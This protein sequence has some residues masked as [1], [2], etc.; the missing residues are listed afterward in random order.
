MPR[1]MPRRA[2]R[3][4]GHLYRRGKVWWFKWFD[5]QGQ[6]HW[7]S[8]G[9]R[10]RA[11]AET[12]LRDQLGQRD[13]GAPVLPDPRR[14]SVDSLLEILKTEYRLNRRRSLDRADLSCRHLLR[15]FA[16][17]AAA[18]VT[19]VDV[20]KYCDLRLGEGVAPATVNRELAALRRAYRLAR[21][22]GVIATMPAITALQE[23]NVRTGFLE[24]DQFTTVCRYLQPTEADCARFMYI[25]GWR[26]RSEVFPLSWP[27]VDWAG[28]LVR[29]EP[30]TT[31]NRKGR[32]FPL[33]PQLRVLLERRLEHTRRCER[34]QGRI[35]PYVFHRSGRPIKSMSKAWRAGCRKAGAPGR[36]LHDLR[37][38]AVRNLERAGVS[39]SVA[40]EMTGHKTE[41]VYRR[42]AIVEEADL[43]QAGL[44]LA[45]VTANGDSFG[46]LR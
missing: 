5:A 42:Y 36:L 13:R 20:A 8:S 15:F 28:G 26:S 6:P 44:K 46:D 30:G 33:M 24:P 18:S 27:Q 23:D 11:V 34:A 2:R 41:S 29:L 17:R 10:E 35:I 14:L 39:R 21:R 3:G 1:A 38:T 31:K 16:G 45:A 19:G 7:R 4:S 12:M 43:V 22:D 9:S 32:A 25:T 40:M 37:R